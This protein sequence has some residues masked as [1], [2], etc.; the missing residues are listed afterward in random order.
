MFW[1][2]KDILSPIHNEDDSTSVIKL[3]H[4][5]SLFQMQQLFLDYDPNLVLFN[6]KKSK[7]IA[8]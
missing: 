2:N 6:N 7:S 1:I 8:L 4:Q 3:H 5:K